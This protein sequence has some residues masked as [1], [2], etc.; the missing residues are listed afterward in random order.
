MASSSINSS[1]HPNDDGN[2]MQ[3]DN[4]AAVSQHC[5]S[6]QPPK[7]AAVDSITSGQQKR[8]KITA[9]TSHYCVHQYYLESHDTVFWSNNPTTS[10]SLRN[11][12]SETKSEALNVDGDSSSSGEKNH[13]VNCSRRHA[14][15]PQTVA[16][17]MAAS[18][19]PKF[20]SRFVRGK[21]IT[22]AT[23]KMIR[24]SMRVPQAATMNRTS[25]PKC[26]NQIGQRL[27]YQAARLNARGAVTKWH[28][29]R[30]VWKPKK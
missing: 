1:A 13:A 22:T 6:D 19:P 7:V 26:V 18:I 25:V 5:G 4:L 23:T 14:V 15:W 11:S 24:R 20:N 12:P 29:Q 30:H 10:T 27:R 2:G 21:M 28:Q 16:P 17:D 8:S 3:T 9:T